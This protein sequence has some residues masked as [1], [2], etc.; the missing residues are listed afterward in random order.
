MLFPKLPAAHQ[1]GVL[2]VGWPLSVRL[3]FS[4]SS[5]SRY[6]AAAAGEGG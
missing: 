4:E 1:S 6:D 5:I 2:A 3:P